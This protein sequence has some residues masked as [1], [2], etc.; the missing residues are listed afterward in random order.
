MWMCQNVDMSKFQNVDMSHDNLVA[1]TA[2][3][4]DNLVA[5]TATVS[6]SSCVFRS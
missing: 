3:V 6:N 1:M 2:T 4:S 5:M